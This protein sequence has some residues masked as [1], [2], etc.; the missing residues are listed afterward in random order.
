MPTSEIGMAITGMSEARQVCRKR[1]TTAT[2]SRIATKIVFT[3]S[4]TDFRNDGE[5]GWV[6]ASAGT[7][8][9]AAAA[10]S[11]LI[12]PLEIPPGRATY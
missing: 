7:M 8:E 3:T 10:A 12:S 9:G 1:K 4:R 5:A 6:C 2:T 11:C